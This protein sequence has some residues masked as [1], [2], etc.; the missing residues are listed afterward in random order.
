[1]ASAPAE[2][3][4]SANLKDRRFRRVGVGVATGDSRR[5]GAGRIWVAVVYTD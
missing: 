2:A 4:R 3:I 5:F 1:V